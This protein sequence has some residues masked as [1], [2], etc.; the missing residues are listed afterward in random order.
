MSE[1]LTKKLPAQSDSEKLDLIL[2]TI[3]NLK[4]HLERLEIRVDNIDSRLDRLETRADN[5][6]SRLEA[7]ELKVEQRLYDTRPI[8][9]KVVADIG[10]LQDGQHRLE[11]GQESLREE[12]R[13]VK[14]AVREVSRDQIVINDVI[15]KIH[16]D[17]HAIDERLHR[18]EVNRN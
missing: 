8:W 5:I 4:G 13:D 3:Q 7:L 17:F 1:D 6:D 15:R 11:K 12:I 2:T 10:Q 18:L 9:Q 14:A 16:L